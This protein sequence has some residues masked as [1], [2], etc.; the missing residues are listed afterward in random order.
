MKVR[1]WASVELASQK[2]EG[3]K[4]IFDHVWKTAVLERDTMYTSSISHVDDDGAA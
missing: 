4:S 3:E 2:E 1:S